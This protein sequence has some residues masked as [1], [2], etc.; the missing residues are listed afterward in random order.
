MKY[1]ISGAAGA[2]SATAATAGI[3]KAEAH[4]TNPQRLKIYEW[5][6]GPGAAAADANYTVR[7]KRQS[8]AGTWTAVTARPLDSGSSE[9]TDR[10]PV[11]GRA[12]TAAGTAGNILGEFGFNQRGGFRWVAVPGGELII[13]ATAA[14]GIII[15]YVVVEGTAVNYATIYVE[16]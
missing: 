10:V 11:G 15:E 13:P 1:S 6:V 4:G 2:A 9:D 12:S 7:A 3:I 5:S 8:T 16:D 14:N